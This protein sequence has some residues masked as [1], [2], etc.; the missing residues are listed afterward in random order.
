MTQPLPSGAVRLTL[1]GLA[2][3]IWIT[4]IL[5]FYL[6]LSLVVD[7]GGTI[8]DALVVYFS[9]FT[10]LTNLLTALV[11]SA[12][13]LKPHDSVWLTRSG[14]RAA[15]VVYMSVVGMV[16]ALL[17]RDLWAPTGLTKFC[18]V[19]LHDAMPVLYLMCW[20]AWAPKGTLRWRHAALWLC[21]PAAYFLY[22]LVRGAVT[23]VY[24]YPF[25]DLS[26]LGAAGVAA[27]AVLLLAAFWSLGLM[28][29]AIDRWR[30]RR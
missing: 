13:V 24:P 23:G 2:G 29:V 7:G 15:V 25:I 28:V 20:L 8:T 19:I 30:A 12:W 26:K 5:R 10:I 6:T 22:S 9:Y 17:L 27:N 21:Y 4:L 18:D 11:L 16:Y 3:L 14:V 1:A